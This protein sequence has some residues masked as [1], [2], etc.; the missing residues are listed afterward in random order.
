M[1]GICKLCEQLQLDPLEDVRVLVLLHKLGAN[2]KPAEISREEWMSGCNRL[3]LDT[4]AKFTNYLPALDTGFMDRDEFKEFY[5]VCTYI[6]YNDIIE[7]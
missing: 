1:S 3:Q 5:K 6:T 2:K 4:V 7:R